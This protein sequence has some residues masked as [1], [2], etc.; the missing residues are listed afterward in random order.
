[1]TAEAPVSAATMPTDRLHMRLTWRTA[2][3]PAAVLPATV[4]IR[5]LGKTDEA[6]IGRL[7]WAAF[8]GTSDDQYDAP[9]D[10][11]RDA[12]QTVAGVWGPVVWDAS[13]AGELDSLVIAAAIVVRDS[14]HAGLPLLAFALTDPGHQRRGIGQRLIEESIARLDSNGVHELHLAVTPGNPAVRLYQRLGFE[15]VA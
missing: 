7:M 11:Q 14:A 4:L 10:A 13:L 9:A 12:A 3:R 1:M 6:A 15:V 8:R 5:P 2:P